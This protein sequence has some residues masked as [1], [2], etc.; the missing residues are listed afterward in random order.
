[1]RRSFRLVPLARLARRLLSRWY[2]RVA[3]EVFEVR[4]AWQTFYR[5][6]L[7]S[8]ITFP[9]ASNFFGRWAR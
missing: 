8:G 3:R 7:F 6:A 9:V 1:M 5:P 4:I 2:R